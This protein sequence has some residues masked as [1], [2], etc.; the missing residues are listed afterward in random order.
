MIRF[1]VVGTFSYVLT[2]GQFQRGH[3]LARRQ[4]DLG[5]GGVPFGRLSIAVLPFFGAMIL[6]LL[7]LALVPSL[8]TWLPNLVFGPRPS[9]LC[10]PCAGTGASACSSVIDVP[11]PAT[12]SSRVGEVHRRG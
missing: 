1:A 2:V 9:R 7:I 12:L 6:V 11:L 5:T 3:F 10:R 8:V 4:T